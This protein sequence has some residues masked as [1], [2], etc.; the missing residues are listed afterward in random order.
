[1]T[2][3]RL[4]E[5]IDQVWST[6]VENTRRAPELQAL[7]KVCRELYPAQAAAMFLEIALHDALQRLGYR[8]NDH[9]PPIS[10]VSGGS[11]RS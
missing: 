7:A 1:M 8:S 3:A 5:A 9:S 2:P 10:A 6:V 4:I 11:F